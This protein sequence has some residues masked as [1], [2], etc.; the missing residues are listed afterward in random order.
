MR[1]EP[2]STG[3]IKLDRGCKKR[4]IFKIYLLLCAKHYANSFS[5]IFSFN[6]AYHLPFIREEK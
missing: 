2:L 4:G 3:N 5:N 1:H 6:P